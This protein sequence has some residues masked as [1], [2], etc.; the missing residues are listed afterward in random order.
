[1]LCFER[2][3]EDDR[4]LLQIGRAH[5]TQVAQVAQVPHGIHNLVVPPSGSAQGFVGTLREM[6]R[7]LRQVNRGGGTRVDQDTRVVRNVVDRHGAFVKGLQPHLPGGQTVRWCMAA[8]IHY[9]RGFDSTF[10]GS[11]IGQVQAHAEID[12]AECHRVEGIKISDVDVRFIDAHECSG[13]PVGAIADPCAHEW[14]CVSRLMLKGDGHPATIE[15]EYPPFR[16]G[17]GLAPGA[18]ARDEHKERR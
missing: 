6:L 7:D 11:A 4:A 16:P 17:S 18:V 9:L 13:D 2:L 10:D 15:T 3:G 1:M 5:S 14:S 12:V 8:R